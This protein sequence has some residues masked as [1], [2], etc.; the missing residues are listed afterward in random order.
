MQ[1]KNMLNGL[2]AGIKRK[3]KYSKNQVNRSCRGRFML[4]WELPSP[5]PSL[6]PP[7]LLKPPLS[8]ASPLPLPP[9]PTAS[10]FSF[11]LSPLLSSII[12]LFLHDTLIWDGTSLKLQCSPPEIF[13]FASLRVHPWLSLPPF[14]F[15]KQ[16][17]FYVCGFY[18]CGLCI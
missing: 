18:V 10:L 13:L 17:R 7:L 2:K 3:E 15:E 11:L 6:A 12:A 14:S 16:T 4:F 1:R 5:S 9:F 8:T